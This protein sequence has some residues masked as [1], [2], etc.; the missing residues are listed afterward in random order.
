MKNDKI[1]PECDA[2][3]ETVS[4]DVFG[5]CELCA[6]FTEEEDYDYDRDEAP[7]YEPRKDFSYFGEA[8][9]EDYDYDRWD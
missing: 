4:L 1:C 9:F 8:G 2:A 7:E 5:Q 6:N 3:G